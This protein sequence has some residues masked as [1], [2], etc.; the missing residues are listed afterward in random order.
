MLSLP[1]KLREMLVQILSY[2]GFADVFSLVTGLNLLVI[3]CI[4]LSLMSYAV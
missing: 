1:N 4:E 3:R 2:L